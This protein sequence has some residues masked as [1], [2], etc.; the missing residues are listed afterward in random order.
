V[1]SDEFEEQ[2]GGADCAVPGE[3]GDAESSIPF[4]GPSRFCLVSCH[5]H[6]D[7]VTG[8]RMSMAVDGGVDRWNVTVGAVTGHSRWPLTAAVELR[9][10]IRDIGGGIE[11]DE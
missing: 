10:S 5:M 7:P 9:Y 11:N 8:R 3:Q 4:C 2:P 1:V 6:D